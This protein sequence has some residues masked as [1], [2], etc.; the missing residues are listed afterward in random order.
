MATTPRTPSLA[1]MTCLDMLQDAHRVCRADNDTDNQAIIE[2][3][4]GREQAR[5]AAGQWDFSD[6]DGTASIDLADRTTGNGSTTRGRPASQA[7]IDLLT[8]IYTRLGKAL[9]ANLQRLTATQA[10]ELIDA[11]KLEL[12]RAGLPLYGASE[13]QKALIRRLMHQCY[14][15]TAEQMLGGLDRISGQEASQIIDRLT[16]HARQHRTERPAEAAD[17]MYQMPDGTVVKVQITIHGSKKPYAKKLVE[18]DEPKHT[19][20]G[21]RKWEFQYAPGLVNRLTPEMRMT[22]EQAQQWGRLY[23]VCCNCGM[24]LTD[25]KSIER[26][27]G[28]SCC[29]KF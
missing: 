20:K 8:Q 7:A 26:G 21:D 17:G 5:I 18:L 16:A 9:P 1:K 22:L 19:S 2:A 15:D 13:A 11:A 6:F 25:E 10:S 28:P 29:K 12:E 4:I 23:G 24:T 14:P 3:A 27:M